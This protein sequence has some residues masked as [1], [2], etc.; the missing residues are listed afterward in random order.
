M[1]DWYLDEIL[2]RAKPPEAQP[3]KADDWWLNETIGPTY[4]QEGGAGVRRQP[5][6]TPVPIPGNAPPRPSAPRPQA[7]QPQAAPQAPTP[8]PPAVAPPEP[9]DA[10]FAEP[11]AKDW[12]GWAKQT[13][14]GKRDPRYTSL[15]SAFELGIG[16]GNDAAF[17][18]AGQNDAAYGDFIKSELGDK[19]IRRFKDANGY[20]IVGFRGE[21]GKEQ[22]AYVNKPSWEW[23]DIDRAI[24]GA[25]PY[26]PAA[27]VAGRVTGSLPAIAQVGGQMLG[28]AVTS[29]A[30]DAAASAMGSEQGLDVGKAVGATIGAGVG[31]AASGLIGRWLASRAESGLFDKA[32]GRLTDKGMKAAEAA[33][34]DTAQWTDDIARKFAQEFARS[35]DAKVAGVMA[36]V[37]DVGI[38]TTLGQRTK[39]VRQ[40]MNEQAIRDGNWGQTA[41]NKMKDFDE[42]QWQSMVNATMGEIEPGKP[43]MSMRL[44]P[45]R[46]PADYSPSQIGLDVNSRLTMARENAKAAASK[47]WDKVGKLAPTEEARGELFAYVNSE[48]RDMPLLQPTAGTQGSTPTANAMVQLLE[49]LV[50]GTAPK[51][52]SKYLKGN[53]L[54]DI[55][56]VRKILSQTYRDLPKGQDRAAA[57]RVYT[58]FNKWVNDMAEQ[59]MLTASTPDAAVSAAA[60]KTA[61]QMTAQ[62]VDIFDKALGNSNGARIMKKV[63]QTADSPSQIIRE[64]FVGPTSQAVKPG[65]IAALN[66]IKQA[67]QYLPKDEAAALM[68]DL[69]LAYWLRLV[70]NPS[71]ADEAGKM[72][73]PQR[74]LN[75]L[76]N[77]LES[78][79]DVWKTLYSPEEIAFANRLV[80]A[81]ETGPTFHDWT[82]KPNSS[83]SAT[84]AANLLQDFMGLIV[85]KQMAKVVFSGAQQHSG[86]G[87]AAMR[88]ATEQSGRFAQPRIAPALGSDLGA[89]AGGAYGARS[90]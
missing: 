11:D 22:L 23:N 77:S 37:G 40:L 31:Q 71:A 75:N 62:E 70:R 29:G 80:K 57:E 50:E 61:R 33:G 67:A 10:K 7:S 28:A 55:N 78:Q 49:G 88:R 42:R 46:S 76:R 27:G 65:A 9:E 52:V 19:F 12:M 79:R 35:G 86:F 58:G 25:M 18:L 30:Q 54:D 44:A 13:V 24:S 84:T 17:K 16:V 68:G 3:A 14:M 26:I 63:M 43:G 36:E 48:L 34:I 56:E 6:P 90:E 73:N 45:H 39:D 85:G 47:E 20:D 83:R 51:Q 2:G 4:V 60:M 15:P 53:P 82:I 64:L 32:T 41:A 72:Y 87:S 74:M 81:L 21:D 38:P 89:A 1:A 59:G 69:K 8:M 5:G 66:A